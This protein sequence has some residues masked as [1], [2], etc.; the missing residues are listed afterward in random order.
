MTGK[1]RGRPFKGVEA[2]LTRSIRLGE[3]QRKIIESK[4]GT[5]QKWVDEC[6]EAEFGGVHEA[7]IL[8]AREVVTIDDF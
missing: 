2:R 3:S 8:P 5:V 7:K 4:H 1:R 6:F